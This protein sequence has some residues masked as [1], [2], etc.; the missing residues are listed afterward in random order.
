MDR[1]DKQT[2]SALM[3]RIHSRNTKPELTLRKM[4][5]RMGYR[6]RLHRADLP[7]SP[8]IVFPGRRK[9]IFVHGCYWHRHRCRRGRSMPTTRIAFWDEKFTRNRERDRTARRRLRRSGWAVLVVWECQLRDLDR[10]ARRCV[11]FLGVE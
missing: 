3:G 10:V 9:V 5:Y 8:D 4:L 1:L 6:Y 11:E 2:R 7:G